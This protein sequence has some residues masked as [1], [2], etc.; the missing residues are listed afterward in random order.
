MSDPARLPQRSTRGKPALNR[1]TPRPL[2]GVGKYA[3]G[4]QTRD[5]D[6]DVACAAASARIARDDDAVALQPNC[7]NV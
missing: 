2:E 6:V 3:I 7:R 5:H 4:L 1:G